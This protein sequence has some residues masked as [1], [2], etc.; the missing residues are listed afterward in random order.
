MTLCKLAEVKVS[1]T[2]SKGSLLR[3]LLHASSF[4][5]FGGL[6]P[7]QNFTIPSSRTLL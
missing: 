5:Q 3:Q 2:F 1:K 4:S 7:L 6:S